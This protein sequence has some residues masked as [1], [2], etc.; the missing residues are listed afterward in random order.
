MSRW[1]EYAAEAHVRGALGLELFIVLSTLAGE[2]DAVR[3]ALPDH[4][5]YQR[6]LELA[7]RLVLAGSAF[8]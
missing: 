5:A 3:A 7:D 4:L 6:E 2:A 1:E 8:G